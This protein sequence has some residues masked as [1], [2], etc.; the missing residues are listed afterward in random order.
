MIIQRHIPVPLLL[1]NCLINA[2]NSVHIAWRQVRVAK[3]VP[4]MRI[5]HHRVRMEVPLIH[6]WYGAFGVQVDSSRAGR[7][8]L[9]HSAPM[10]RGNVASLRVG[11][12]ALH[13]QIAPDCIP[14]ILKNGFG[15]QRPT[16]PH[17]QSS[18]ALLYSSSL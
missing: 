15:I 17:D 9:R 2:G 8:C 10:P 14:I 7:L 18:Q 3:T 16:Q 6:R 12:S 1:T 11:V 5:R 4:S 13:L